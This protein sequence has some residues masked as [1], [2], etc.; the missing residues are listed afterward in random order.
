V[1]LARLREIQRAKTKHGTV[2]WDSLVG[3]FDPRHFE[4]TVYVP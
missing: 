2:K 1:H 4:F 3:D